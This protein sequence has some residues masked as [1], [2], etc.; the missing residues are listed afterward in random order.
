MSS[1]M[2]VR[3]HIQGCV[4]DEHGSRSNDSHPPSA[5]ITHF[6]VIQSL[7]SPSPG[8]SC[9]NP[10]RFFAIFDTSNGLR[11]QDRE[12]VPATGSLWAHS[13]A[14]PIFVCHTWAGLGDVACH[15]PSDATCHRPRLLPDTSQQLEG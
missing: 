3:A 1:V 2:F 8:F 13:A 14:L 9:P 7:V 6:G 10:S 5:S 11:L 4:L 15:Y 12:P